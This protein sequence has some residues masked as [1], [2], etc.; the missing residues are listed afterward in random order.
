MDRK[1]KREARLGGIVQACEE[2]NVKSR[3]HLKRAIKANFG[4][5]DQTAKDYIKTLFESDRLEKVGGRIVP[6]PMASVVEAEE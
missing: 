3:L 6:G 4:V 2:N 1:T 5:T